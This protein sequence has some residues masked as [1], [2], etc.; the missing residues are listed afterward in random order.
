L[1]EAG[2]AARVPAVPGWSDGRFA[3]NGRHADLSRL[4]ADEEEE[5]TTMQGFR[6]RDKPSD[7]KQ[8]AVALL[9]DP[10][11]RAGA[12]RYSE[13]TVITPQLWL[14]NGRSPAK[15]TGKT[16]KTPPGEGFDGF[17]GCFTSAAGDSRRLIFPARMRSIGLC[18]G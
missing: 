8:L 9:A 12:I 1:L 14:K 5:Q 4:L 17:A 15:T 6:H 3:P 18:R 7:R 13:L 2:A 16:G 10:K 11:H